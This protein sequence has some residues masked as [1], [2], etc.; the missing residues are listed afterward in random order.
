MAASPAPVERSST[1][2]SIAARMGSP[3]AATGGRGSDGDSGADSDYTPPYGDAERNGFNG[4]G[5]RDARHRVDA[6]SESAT[7]ESAGSV[8]SADSDESNTWAE[9]KAGED[10]SNALSDSTGASTTAP[11]TAGEAR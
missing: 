10:V 11:L 7:S 3:N 2:S 6:T 8:G 5:A 9:A 4:F 1:T